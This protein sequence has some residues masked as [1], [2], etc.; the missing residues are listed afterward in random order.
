MSKVKTLTEEEREMSGGT[1][2]AILLS[3]G[4]VWGGFKWFDVSMEAVNALFSGLAFATLIFTVFLQRRELQ[5]TRKELT[6]T[7]AAQEASEKALKAQAEASEQSAHLAA[8]NFLLSHYQAELAEARRVGPVRASERPAFERLKMREEK[9]IEIL[10]SV[11][12][13][14]TAKH[15]A[16]RQ[17]DSGISTDHP[18]PK[19]D[20]SAFLKV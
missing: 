13:E 11:Y 17:T 6:R 19:I 1:L 4:F 15:A 12:A 9:L 2:A 5:E 7:A 16:E 20:P 3:I 18:T 10:D 14:V 8:I